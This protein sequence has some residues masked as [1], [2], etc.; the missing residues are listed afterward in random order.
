MREAE[1]N[2]GRELFLLIALLFLLVFNY[3]L[4]LAF[5]RTHPVFGVPLIILYLLGGW[6]LFIV[7]IFLSVRT[8][9]RKEDEERLGEDEGRNGP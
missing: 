5:N 6:L 4:M 3:P 9:G 1:Y 7:I 2:R 8:L